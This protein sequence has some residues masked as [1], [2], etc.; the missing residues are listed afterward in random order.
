MAPDETEP[1]DD[2]PTRRMTRISWPP[3][4]PPP[5]ENGIVSGVIELPDVDLPTPR[6]VPIEPPTAP[7][8]DRAQTEPRN[9]AYDGFMRALELR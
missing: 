4:G 7:D 3:P 1:D 8:L 5:D 6:M 9:P 2:K